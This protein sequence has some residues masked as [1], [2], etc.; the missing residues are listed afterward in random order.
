MSFN[1]KTIVISTPWEALE[2]TDA[3]GSGAPIV[4]MTV[5]VAI[6]KVKGEFS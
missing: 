1:A 2:L 5:R 6:S 3:T 4:N